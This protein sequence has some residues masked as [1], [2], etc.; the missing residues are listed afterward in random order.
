MKD[1]ETI[2]FLLKIAG[3]LITILIAGISF[4]LVASFNNL[5]KLR[6]LTGTMKVIIDERQIQCSHKHSN[7]DVKFSRLETLA[8]NHENRIIILETKQKD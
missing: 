2:F 4:F 5:E 7:I 6:E 8:Q 3:G 1:P